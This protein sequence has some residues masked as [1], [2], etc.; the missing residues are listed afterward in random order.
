MAKIPSKTIAE[1]ID[2][3]MTDCGAVTDICGVPVCRWTHMPCASAMESGKCLWMQ[4]MA[5]GRYENGG[6]D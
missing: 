4:A 1:L 5:E 2:I 3:A 6:S